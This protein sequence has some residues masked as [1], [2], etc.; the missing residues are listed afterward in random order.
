MGQRVLRPASVRSI[1]RHREAV[2]KGGGISG[3]PLFQWVS[4]AAIAI[5]IDLHYPADPGLDF[6]PVYGAKKCAGP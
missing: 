5:Q 4:S 1:S 3:C 2:L 6:S